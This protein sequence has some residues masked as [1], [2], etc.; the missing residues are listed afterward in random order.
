[1]RLHKRKN[2]FE[3]G[4]AKTYTDEVFEVTGQAGQ[5]PN[6]YNLIDERGEPITGKVYR[7]QLQ[8][9]SKKPETYQVHVIRRRRRRGHPPEALVEWVGHPHLQPQWMYQRDL[10][11]L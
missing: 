4:R 8:R 6:T 11:D 3:K 9:L 7:R 2:M 5:N 10:I 1:M